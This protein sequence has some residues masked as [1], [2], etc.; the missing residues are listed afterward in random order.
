MSREE[1]DGGKELL[2]NTMTVMVRIPQI[3]M[4]RCSEICE[5][6]RPAR[7]LR[8]RDEKC[9]VVGGRRTYLTREKETK[10]IQIDVQHGKAT[11]ITVSAVCNDLSQLK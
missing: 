11:R 7:M 4:R 3:V 10:S 5:D 1:A 2:Q 9:F 8:L 6:V